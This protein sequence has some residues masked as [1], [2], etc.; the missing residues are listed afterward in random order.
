MILIR[1][2]IKWLTWTE[3]TLNSTLWLNICKFCLILALLQSAEQGT[4]IIALYEGRMLSSKGSHPIVWGSS[5]FELKSWNS[6]SNNCDSKAVFSAACS[7]AHVS[8]VVGQE[9]GTRQPR[10]QMKQPSTKEHPPTWV[11]DEI[12]ETCL[13]SN[14]AARRKKSPVVSPACCM[15]RRFQEPGEGVEIIPEI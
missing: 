8:D 4:T 13:Q 7:T 2:Q 11:G 5:I 15:T 14:L 10:R 1:I 12:G 6:N 9:N 3:S